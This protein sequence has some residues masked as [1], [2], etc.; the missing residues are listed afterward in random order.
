MYVRGGEDTKR[1]IKRTTSY[2]L[3]FYATAVAALDKSLRE[4]FISQQALRCDFT[5][6]ISAKLAV[7]R[8]EAWS[9]CALANCIPHVRWLR[10]EKGLYAK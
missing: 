4:T 6:F 2:L 5:G 3:G 7:Q 9:V 8:I 10:L 1:I